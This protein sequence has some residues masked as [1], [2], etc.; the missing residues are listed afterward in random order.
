MTIKLKK[1]KVTKARLIKFEVKKLE[2]AA[3]LKASPKKALTVKG[4]AAE[5][6]ATAS[7]PAKREKKR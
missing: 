6:V 2:K 7:V 1:K 3:L 5:A 4:T